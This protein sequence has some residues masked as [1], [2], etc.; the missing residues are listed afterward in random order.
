[1]TLFVGE[2][3]DFDQLVDASGQQLSVDEVNEKYVRGDIR[4]VTEQ[5]RYPLNTIVTMVES[6]DYELNPEFQRRHRWSKLKQSRLIESFIMNVPIPPIFL[7]E[8]KY[9]QYEVMDGLQRLTAIADFYRG[10]YK[11]ESLQEWKEL[12]GLTY[13]KLPEQVRRGIDRRYLSSIILLRETA[14]TEAQAQALKQMVF[15]RINSGGDKLEAQESRN[16]LYNGPLNQLCIRLAAL[17]SFRRMW[18]I[19]TPETH[20]QPAPKPAALFDLNLEESEVDENDVTVPLSYE[21][22]LATHPLYRTMQDVELVLRFFANRQ[23]EDVEQ[24]RLQDYLDLFLKK[25]NEFNAP[26]LIEYEKLFTSTSDFVFALLGEKAF[27][28][29]RKRKNSQGSGQ[30]FDRPTKVVYDALMY[31]ASENLHRQDDL[32]RLPNWLE[33]MQD[34]YVK[35]QVLFAG[36]STNK[37]DLLERRRLALALF[38]DAR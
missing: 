33:R 19:P 28:L 11:L 10:V 8:V 14:K 35:N 29:F 31:S 18:D 15:E 32:L 13:S 16:A 3:I 5:A 24:G 30:W 20:V 38:S 34:F 7:Y 2:K 12:N 23:I 37:Q 21:A 4:I 25:G 17:P 36:R 1:M 22:A 26:L 9:S 6:G 27:R